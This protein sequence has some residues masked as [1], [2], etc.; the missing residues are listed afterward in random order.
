MFFEIVTKYHDVVYIN[1]NEKTK[2]SKNSIYLS[3][4]V[5]ETISKIHNRDVLL[6]VFS[7]NDDC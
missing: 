4:H 2:Y 3:L 5:N 1:F 7:I 6:F